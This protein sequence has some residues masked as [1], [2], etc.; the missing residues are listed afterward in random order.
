MRR[1][2]AGS[3]DW[4][5]TKCKAGMSQFPLQGT[6]VSCNARMSQFPLQTP[7]IIYLGKDARYTMFFLTDQHAKLTSLPIIC[8]RKMHS[9]L[10]RSWRMPA[11]AL[12]ATVPC[13]SREESM[14]QLV[15]VWRSTHV[16][17]ELALTFS[18]SDLSF[19]SCPVA[20]LLVPCYR[21]D[22]YHLR[23]LLSCVLVGLSCSWQRTNCAIGHLISGLWR[24]SNAGKWLEV[25]HCSK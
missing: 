19:K 4:G 18:L 22:C 21:R 25:C 5:Q 12:F 7:H 16:E 1:P 9:F 8:F 10:A 11:G 6:F 3:Y 2:S 20:V 17:R 15:V 14:T 24:N 13:G 23:N